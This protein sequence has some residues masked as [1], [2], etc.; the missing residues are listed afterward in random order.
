MP[1]KLKR[2]NVNR[3]LLSVHCDLIC[4]WDLLIPLILTTAASAVDVGLHKKVIGSRNHDST[5]FGYGTTILITSNKEMK[6]MKIIK[7]NENNKQLIMK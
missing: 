1:V 6:I 3:S 2:C 4:L 5:I 7:C